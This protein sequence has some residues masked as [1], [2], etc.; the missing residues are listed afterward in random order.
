MLKVDSFVGCV[1]LRSLSETKIDCS[2]ISQVEHYVDFVTLLT[3]LG[4]MN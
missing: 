4:F 1:D 3:S 2:N